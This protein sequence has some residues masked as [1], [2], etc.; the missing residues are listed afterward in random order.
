MG[1][2][3]RGLWNG[4]ISSYSVHIEFFMDTYIQARPA[5]REIIFKL[6]S[7]AHLYSVHHGSVGAQFKLIV[8]H[9]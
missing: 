2:R 4:L 9:V 1:Q 3:R 7:S 5:N 6:L 8:C